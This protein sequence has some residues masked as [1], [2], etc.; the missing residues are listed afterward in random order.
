MPACSHETE[1]T[2]YAQSG[3]TIVLPGTLTYRSPFRQPRSLGLPRAW[4]LRSI[5]RGSIAFSRMRSLQ[6]S[7]SRPP[8]PK[9]VSRPRA[10]RHS[11]LGYDQGESNPPP[12][13]NPSRQ[14]ARKTAAAMQPA[15]RDQ[16]SQTGRKQVAKWPF[17]RIR[18]LTTMA[19]S[20]THTPRMHVRAPPALRTIRKATRT[21]HPP[22]LDAALPGKAGRKRTLGVAKQPDIESWERA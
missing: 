21:R 4:A 8:R 10:C 3:F 19:R 2:Q 1:A 14:M 22:S 5:P 9:Q 6:A 11:N 13:E 17:G 12:G 15:H 20:H 18:R 16:P 7:L